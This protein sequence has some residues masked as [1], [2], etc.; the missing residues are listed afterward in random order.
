M[1]A[2]ILALGH[3]HDTAPVEIRERF[4]FD[5]ARMDEALDGLRRSPV[6]LESVILSTCNRNEIYT[7]VSDVEDGA[8][9]ITSFF[10]EFHGVDRG[11]IDHSFYRF[12]HHRAVEHL[13]TVASGIDSM[14]LGETGITSQIKQA[15][16][17]ARRR[18]AT[19]P[20]LNRLFHSA[21]EAEKKVRSHTHLGEG[22]VSVSSCAV[23]L[24]RKI[25]TRL[26]DKTTVLVGAGETSEQ[27]A[28]ILRDHGVHRF[29]VANR[30]V[31]RAA[32]LADRLG[33]SGIPLDR[34]R[35]AVADADIVI[36]ST[37]SPVVLLD[38]DAV[39]EAMRARRSRP[40]F[41]IDLSV[42]RDVSPDVRR[43]ENV[44][45]YDV[46]DLQSIADA[47]RERRRDEVERAR[48]IIQHEVESFMAWYRALDV[49][50]TIVALRRAFD[51]VRAAE[52]ERHARRFPPEARERL[53]A[54]SRT[55]VNKLLHHPTIELKQAV[56]RGDDA[57]VV[58]AVRRLFDLRTEDSD[59]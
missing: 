16:D 48:E 1:T 7:V 13:F 4:A 43:I 35:E 41:F 39:R 18:Q 27:T 50:P 9:A 52:V 38:G 54:F 24:A 21:F 2:A 51:E 29:V 53:E 37:A 32:A 34:L 36:T 40:L 30:T 59:E 23:D 22:S 5:P 8:D 19:G 11:L 56:R 20:I 33:G 6:V 46:D 58:E 44:F 45:L 31:E 12:A 49:T 28:R 15:F 17:T 14:V 25:F 57:Y 47:N 10:H 42:P 3:N 55:L 26:E